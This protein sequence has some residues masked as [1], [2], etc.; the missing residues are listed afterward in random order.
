V[1]AGAERCDEG[2]A[3]DGADANALVPTAN[4][5]RPRASKN[6]ANRT[7]R[8]IRGRPVGMDFVLMVKLLI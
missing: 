1:G 5:P 4:A 8:V 7:P 2:I 6:R 3:E